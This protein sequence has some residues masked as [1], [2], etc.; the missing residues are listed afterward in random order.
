MMQ[1][2]F[3]RWMPMA[4]FLLVATLAVTQ[5]I[6]AAVRTPCRR[7]LGI[8]QPDTQPPPCQPIICPD[9]R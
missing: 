7:T 4:L 9:T 8:C 5:H 3:Q 6:K 1:D 2:H